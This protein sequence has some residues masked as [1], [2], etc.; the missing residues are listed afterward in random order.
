MYHG[1]LLISDHTCLPY[2]L[3]WKQFSAGLV[4]QSSWTSVTSHCW[5]KKYSLWS[6]SNS[7][8]TLTFL[9]LFPLHFHCPC[10]LKKLDLFKSQLK[11]R[12]I[13]LVFKQ[14]TAV[15]WTR[16]CCSFLGVELDFQNNKKHLQYP[17]MSLSARCPVS[18]GSKPKWE[19]VHLISLRVH[20]LLELWSRQTSSPST[21]DL[22]STAHAFFSSGCQCDESFY[23]TEL[24]AKLNYCSELFHVLRS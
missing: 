18:Q 16:S 1:W 8:L 2:L 11:P 17:C 15:N 19:Q 7:S 22:V 24:T 6:H 3:E 5:K 10:R 21:R 14:A 20:C 23:L 9:S 12:M 13:S 4:N